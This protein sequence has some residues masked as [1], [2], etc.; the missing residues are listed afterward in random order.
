MELAKNIFTVVST[1]I[2]LAAFIKGV[3]ELMHSNAI[4]RYEKF[5]EMS[6]RF[7]ESTEIQK[8]CG[9]LHG[10]NSSTDSVTVQEREVFIC[11]MEEVFFM[12]NSGLMKL[13]LAL[14]SFGYYARLALDNPQFWQA[15][16][17]DEGFYVHFVRFCTLARQYRPA[18]SDKS[19]LVY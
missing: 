3:V 1:V 12:V 17:R 19:S 2:G 11:F 4:R 13:E 14:Y 18:N 16:N 5:H 15:L 7:D 6:V 10:S 8:V 9:L